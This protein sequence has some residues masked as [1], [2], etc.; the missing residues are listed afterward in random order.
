MDVSH[1]RDTQTHP[2][3]LPEKFYTVC[4]MVPKGTSDT[5]PATDTV[6]N[7]S[8]SGKTIIS[9]PMKNVQK[10]TSDVNRL[11]KEDDAI[12]LKNKYHSN[13]EKVDLRTNVFENVILLF[14]ILIPVIGMYALFRL[15]KKKCSISSQDKSNTMFS[16]LTV[17]LLMTTAESIFV[18]WYNI[19]RTYNN[20]KIKR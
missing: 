20:I 16:L 19:Q 2:L 14:V 7:T 1:Q 9:E 10:P 6:K 8:D 3:L 18:Y 5:I 15:N 12:N 4:V 13:T 11:K 17:S